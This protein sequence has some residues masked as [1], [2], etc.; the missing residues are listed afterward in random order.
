MGMIGFDRRIPLFVV[1]CRAETLAKQLNLIR[2]NTISRVK[3]ALA[4]A[5]ATPSFA[6]VLA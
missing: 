2:A 5:F 4:S 6:P 1:A 3:N